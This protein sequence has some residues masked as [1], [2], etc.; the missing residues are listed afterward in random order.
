LES[1]NKSKCLGARKPMGLKLD[2][3][4]QLRSLVD[5]IM[6]IVLCFTT[7]SLTSI[8]TT[9]YVKAALINKKELLIRNLSLHMLRFS[10][11]SG[12]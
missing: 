1:Q 8:F 2:S 11:F 5:L 12:C 7:I 9:T 3:Q 6:L 10:Q 4:N